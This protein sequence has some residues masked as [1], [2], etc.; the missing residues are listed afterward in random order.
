M[1]RRFEDGHRGGAL[2]NGKDGT[3]DVP[4]NALWPEIAADWLIR[5]GW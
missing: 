4:H 2:Y 3:P 5:R 1:F